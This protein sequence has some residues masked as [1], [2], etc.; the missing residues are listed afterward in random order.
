MTVFE[1]NILKKYTPCRSGSI[2]EIVRA[3][4]VVHTELVLIHPF[5]EGNGRVARMLAALMIYKPAFRPWISGGAEVGN[6]E[7]TLL[8]FKPA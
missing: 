1:K 2:E 6:D 4:A 8:L 5:R 7:S 3:L